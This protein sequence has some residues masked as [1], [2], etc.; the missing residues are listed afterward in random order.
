KYHRVLAFNWLK[1]RMLSEILLAD[2]NEL[3]IRMIR[4][5]GSALAELHN[6]RVSGLAHRNRK[7]EV[8]VLYAISDK[9]EFLCPSLAEY[10]KNLV[11]SLTE[12]L[13][14]QPIVYKPIHGDFYAKQVLVDNGQISIVDFD[15]AVLGDPRADIGLFIAHMELD[16]LR[17]LLPENRVVPLVD[18]LL[19]GY[20]HVAGEVIPSSDVNAYTAVGLFQLAHQPFR[21]FEPD[22]TIRTGAILNKVEV[23]INKSSIG[24]PKGFTT[25]SISQKEREINVP[26]VDSFGAGK[27]SKMSFLSRALNPQV[28]ERC[29]AQMYSSHTDE[30]YN[31]SLRSINVVRYKP[32]RRCMVEY[33]ADLKEPNNKKQIVKLLGKAPARRVDTTTYDLCCTLWNNGFHNN[34]PDWISIPQPVG[35]IPEMQMWFQRKVPGTVTTDLLVESRGV[36]LSRRIAEAVHKLH[37]ANIPSRR[38]HTMADELHIL[39]DRLQYVVRLNPQW[40][41]RIRR[42]L[43]NCDHLGANVP[44]YISTGIHRDFYADQVLVDGDRLYLIDLDL[45]SE[46]DPGLDIG[47]FLGHITE[48]SLRVRGDA[49]ALIDIEKAMEDRFLQ[50]AGGH[51]LTSVQTYTTLTLV[52]HIYIST[53][54]SDRKPYTE[55]LLEL[56]EQRLDVPKSMSKQIA[57]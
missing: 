21:Y 47:N 48:Y 12:W 49:E 23:Y 24:R 11:I 1:G 6:Q 53:Q 26:I 54:F 20:K 55:S 4:D 30:E 37:K 44:A 38:K 19:E 22:W 10:S 57:I 40:K 41:Q 3:A 9:I 18:A 28:A 52:R 2:D 16:V 29:L 5:V 43:V 15:E 42:L 34:S 14:D 51:L 7:S 39:H 31:L 35:I 25:R 46:G 50:L 27:D 13:S 56:C 36:E 33:E 45:Y 8:S 32:R 17:G